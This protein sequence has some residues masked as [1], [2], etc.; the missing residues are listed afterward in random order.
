MKRIFGIAAILTFVS[1]GAYSQDDTRR[2]D[3][4]QHFQHARIREGMASGD[5][6]RREAI[7]LKAEQRHIRRTERR[8]MADGKFTA[9]ERRRLHNEQRRAHH[10]I[11]RQRHDR[12]S[13]V[14]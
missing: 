1:W 10:D 2:I 9:S 4:R 3:R 12:Q 13:R 14:N 11:R 7:R 6:T 5:L 8:A